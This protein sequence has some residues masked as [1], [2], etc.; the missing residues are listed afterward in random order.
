MRSNNPKTKPKETELCDQVRETLQ[1][2]ILKD[3]YGF[4]VSS[5]SIGLG[6]L[7]SRTLMRIMYINFLLKVSYGLGRD[8]GCHELESKNSTHSNHK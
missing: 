1:E 8:C 3:E 5:C 7:K 2:T 6:P 4:V